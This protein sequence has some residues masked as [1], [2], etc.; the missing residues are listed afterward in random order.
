MASSWLLRQK[1]RGLARDG[2]SR[3]GP[4]PRAEEAAAGGVS[5][6][7]GGEVEWASNPMRGS[8][9]NAKG[10]TPKVNERSY[11][12]D[13]GVQESPPVGYPAIH[14]AS[15]K[16]RKQ[17]AS[18]VR[19][20]RR[21]GCGSCSRCLAPKCGKCLSC[22]TEGSIDP[23]CKD[24]MCLYFELDPSRPKRLGPVADFSR[25]AHPRM[26]GGISSRI[27]GR[28]SWTLCKQCVLA[29]R[30]GSREKQFLPYSF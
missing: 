15:R 11:R 25:K 17:Q 7:P 19:R 29:K 2:S 8:G 24:Q 30:T 16:R 4:S 21:I 9:G 13:H 27:W 6:R 14:H 23:A 1:F 28:T 20:R 22:T 5:V 26:E 18:S 10:S 3:V 12:Q